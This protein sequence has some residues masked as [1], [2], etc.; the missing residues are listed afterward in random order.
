MNKNGKAVLKELMKN[1]RK[2]ISKIAED[3]DLSRQTVSKK[4]DELRNR[5]FTR[6][7]TAEV[8][9][10]KIGLDERAYI[11]ATA[12]PDSEVR[13]KFMDEAKKLKEVR[14]IYYLFGRF[15]VIL[16]VITT[17][18]ERLDELIDRIHG[19][20]AVKETETLICR[21]AV[22]QESKDPFIEALKD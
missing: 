12:D 3:T 1:G 7:F 17:D 15:D 2:K 19:F 22:K 21:E 11:I 8:D 18:E 20:E 4:I 10:E 5:G 14:Q 16:E 6:S 9:G 13:Q